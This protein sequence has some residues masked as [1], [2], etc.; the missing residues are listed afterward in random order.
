MN[1][2][3]KHLL[4][5]NPIPEPRLGQNQLVGVRAEVQHWTVALLLST[6]PSA[7]PSQLCSLYYIIS[8][9]TLDE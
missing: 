9:G 3:L 2:P 7:W 6:S 5:R 4:D 8:S 1:M